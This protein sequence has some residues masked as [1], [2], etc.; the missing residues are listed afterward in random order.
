MQR[1]TPRV[2]GVDDGPFRKGQKDSV[3]IVGV[4]MEG[5]LLVEG[6][7]IGSFP[8]DGDGATEYLSEW[9]GAMRWAPA[10]QAVLLGGVTLAGLGLV[11]IEELSRRLG[12]PVLSTTRRET[13]TSALGD[14]LRAAG[15]S[16]RLPLLDRIPPC[17][18]VRSGLFVTHAGTT[19]GDADAIVFSTLGL[20][21]IPEPI[22][23][24]HLIGAAL[25][26][27]ASRGR[28]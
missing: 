21:N 28:A 3:P 11:D 23:I 12:V 2:L 13:G 25:E 7:A 1:K 16:E 8:V 15:L 19:A 6:V 24:A 14:A 26:R 20:S 4:V 5:S 27:G 17:R 18:E 22:R 10:L 9:I